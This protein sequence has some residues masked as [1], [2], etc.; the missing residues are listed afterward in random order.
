MRA[1]PPVKTAMPSAVPSGIGWLRCKLPVKMKKPM[2][3][4][5]T[6]SSRQS[7]MSLSK[8]TKSSNALDASGASSLTA[9]STWSCGA[10]Q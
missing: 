3:S 6:A 2:T 5:T 10:Q 1:T 8:P 4:S 9:Y 7:K